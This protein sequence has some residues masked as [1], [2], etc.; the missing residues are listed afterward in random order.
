M[1][2]IIDMGANEK[3]RIAYNFKRLREEKAW[4]QEEVA[5]IG[6]V[7]RNYVSQVKT[8]KCGFGGTLDVHHIRYPSRFRQEDCLDNLL[9]VC[10]KCHRLSHGI[11]D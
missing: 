5:E 7:E 10:R 2:T 3:K 8:G 9:V 4:T 11:R 6:N 1:L